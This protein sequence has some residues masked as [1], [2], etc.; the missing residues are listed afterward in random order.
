MYYIK[1]IMTANPLTLTPYNSIKDARTLMDKAN[2]RH[3]PILSDKKELIGIVA[4]K[5][6]LRASV[7][8]F[9]NL[10]KETRDRIDAGIPLIEIMVPKVLAV[11]A[12]TAVTIAAAMLVESKVGCLPVL[13][14]GK[15]LSGIVTAIDFLRFTLSLVGR[16]QKPSL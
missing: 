10:D 6:V 5:E 15:K 3:I 14:D 2:I 12:D 7:S 16:L 9:A 4:R 8:I 11:E 1:D 13:E